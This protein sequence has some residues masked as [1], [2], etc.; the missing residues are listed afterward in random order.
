SKYK[1][2]KTKARG[3]IKVGGGEF[4]FTQDVAFLAPDKFR[5]TM[6]VDV[7]GK[8]VTIL[9]IINGD[10]V[11]ITADGMD[12]DINTDIK[13]AVKDAIHAF[14]VA[15]LV[16]LLRDKDLE[17]SLL[18][19]MKVE[20]KPAVGVRVACKGQKDVNLYFDKGTGLLAK[21]EQRIV[22]PMSGKEMLQ[23]RIILEYR[24]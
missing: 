11:S 2:G 9:T 10:K 15:R 18:G 17:L 23:E 6:E 12:I 24:K 7:N 19:E 14:R 22:D 20:G 5:D 4:D 13:T 21:T 8:K 3:K 1:A 16:T